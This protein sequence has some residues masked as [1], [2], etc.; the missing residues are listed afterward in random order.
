MRIDDLLTKYCE[1]A[2]YIRGLS[3]TT[4]RRHR[5]TMR[6]LQNMLQVTQLEEC[7]PSVVREFFYRGRSERSWTASSYEA[8]HVTLSKFFR[9]C[10][11]QGYISEDPTVGIENPKKTRRIPRRLTQQ[12]ALRVLELV[13]NYP[14]W[15]AYV[16]ARNHAIFATFIFAGLRR[17]ELIGLGYADVD[18]E[19]RTIFVQHG[20]GDKDRHVPMNPTLAEI[21]RTYTTKRRDAGRV[22]PRFFTGVYGDRP[23]TELGLLELV[24][25]VSRLMN[26][27]FTAHT[28]RHTFATLMLEGGCDIYSISKMLGHAD[29][30][31]T[32]LYLA[33]SSKHLRAQIGKHPL[34]WGAGS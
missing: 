24:R 19:N 30:R 1:Y 5:G 7:T 6:M 13:R 16:R 29:I 10:V 26:L 21:L 22:C 23:L 18:I 25:K 2:I 12:E 11:A 3:R 4:V 15:P 14:R 8:F 20:K 32:T 31:M 34:S 33:A 27:Q 28:F 9:W 17:A